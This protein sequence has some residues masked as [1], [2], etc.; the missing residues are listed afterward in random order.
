MQKELKLDGT[1]GKEFSGTYVFQSITWAVSNKITS[2][3]TMLN[4]LTRITAID[5]K[6]LQAM[7]LDATMIKRPNSITI[8]VLMDEDTK[9]GLPLP[10]GELLMAMADSINGYGEEDRDSLKKLKRQWG[11]P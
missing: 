9:T 3:C 4:P 2:E 8:E 6:K 10:L 7:T 11:L 1:F 5:L